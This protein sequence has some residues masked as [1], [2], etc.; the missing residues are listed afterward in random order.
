MNQQDTKLA[1]LEET[2]ASVQAELE[3][4]RNKPSPHARKRL[5]KAQCYFGI[6]YK[7][8]VVPCEENNHRLDA[9]CFDLGNYYYTEQEA[10]LARDKQLAYVRITDALRDAEG[11][12]VA[13]WSNNSQS[14]CYIHYDHVASA[15]QL[16]YC[17]TTQI[18]P[19]ELYSSK[20]AWEQV[21]ATHA[22]DIKLYLEVV[23]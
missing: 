12:W 5:D 17:R 23:A 7:G 19:S 11:D 10:L 20:E 4:M 9:A 15:V 16:T 21:I 14:K 8:S 22:D 6:D 3:A 1:Q 18:A 2:L 13:N